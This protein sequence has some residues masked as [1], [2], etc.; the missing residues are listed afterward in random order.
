MSDERDWPEAI[1]YFREDQQL[2][3]PGAQMQTSGHVSFEGAWLHIRLRDRDEV[4]TVR[5]DAVDRVVR[6]LP[7][8]P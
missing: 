1:V 2:S 4:V 5:A 8:K 6:R 3:P 7:E